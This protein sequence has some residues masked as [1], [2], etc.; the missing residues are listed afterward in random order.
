M[1]SSALESTSESA[2]SRSDLGLIAGGG[3]YP[4]LIARAA[5]SSGVPVRAIGFPGITS[6][7][8]EGEVDSM[9]W[10]KFGQVESVFRTLKSEEIS[11]AI[12]AGRVHHNNIF[13][14]SRMDLRGLK[15]IGRL[16]NKKADTILGEV[17]AE[18]ARE[19]IE[20]IDST[21]FLRD[22]MPSAGLMTPNVPASDEVMADIEFG[23]EHAR[24]IAGLD[25]GQTI[26]VKSGSVVAVEAMEG[27]DL[28]IQRA[29]QVAGTGVVVC[30]V[31]K[32]QQDKRFDVPVIGLTTIRHLVAAKAAAL[33]F[34]GGEVLF[35]N[36]KEAITL[37]EQNGLCIL[38]V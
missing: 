18:F 4:I 12:M 6:P 13:K 22:C 19:H 7:E 30:K 3:E 32:P 5:R 34:P 33:A 25:I 21:L 8:L 9:H 20:I 26:V 11:R 23:I 31:A 24:Q 35:F 29:G 1:S 28:T 27:T 17:V 15:L 10:I 37:A 14:N 38:A 36:Q 2:T 16:V